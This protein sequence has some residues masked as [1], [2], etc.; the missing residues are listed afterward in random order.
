VGSGGAFS[1]A[2]DVDGLRREIEVM[3]VAAIRSNKIKSNQ[4]KYNVCTTT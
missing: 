4:L 3:A 1:A 2:E